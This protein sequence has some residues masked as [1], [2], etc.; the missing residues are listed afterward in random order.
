MREFP[1]RIASLETCE[2]LSDPCLPLWGIFTETMVWLGKA[3]VGRKRLGFSHEDV[4][5]CKRC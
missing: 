3:N 1:G 4:R 2:T 5:R